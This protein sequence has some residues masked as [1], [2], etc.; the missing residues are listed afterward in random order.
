MT[1]LNEICRILHIE[2]QTNTKSWFGEM[3]DKGVVIVDTGHHLTSHPT[4][5]KVY[6]QKLKVISSLLS[7]VLH[8]KAIFAVN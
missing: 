4:D 2:N 3:R 8:A 1:F 6:L 5:I 7:K